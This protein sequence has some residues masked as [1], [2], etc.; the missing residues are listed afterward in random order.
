M[1]LQKSA[2]Y[3]SIENFKECFFWS[4]FYSSSGKTVGNL[5]F[6]KDFPYRFLHTY[7]PETDYLFS[8]TEKWDSSQWF[9]NKHLEIIL[10]LLQSKTL[11]CL[12][13]F[14]E[15]FLP[16]NYIFYFFPAPKVWLSSSRKK[17][18]GHDDT[19]MLFGKA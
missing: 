3:W 2:M 15:H 4:V 7:Q 9:S 6:H 17:P 19:H 8:S 11:Q 1:Y 13:Q 10:S 12:A 18:V 16:E 14:E 5:Q